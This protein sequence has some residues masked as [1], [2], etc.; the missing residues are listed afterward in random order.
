MKLVTH[1]TDWALRLGART[2]DGRV[3]DVS[4]GYFALMAATSA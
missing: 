4:R 2:E 3:V 1:S